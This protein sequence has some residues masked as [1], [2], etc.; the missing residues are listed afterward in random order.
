MARTPFPVASAYAP[1]PEALLFE[2][3]W[4]VCNQV[5]GIYQVLRS[6]VPTMV[7]RW[8]ERYWLVGPYE[9][10]QA[11]LEFEPEEPPS[12]DP[13][14]LEALAELHREGL[15]VHAGRWLVTGR[16]RVLLLEHAPRPEREDPERLRALHERMQR[17]F[18]VEPRPGD[19][20]LEGVLSFGEAVR[21]CLGTVARH[22]RAQRG[23]RVLA[24]FHEW[25]GG[26]ALPF[27]RQEA[28]REGLPLETVFTTHATSVGRYVASSHGDLYERLPS[29]D[30]DA[31]ATHFA[32]RTQHQ[33]ESL[34]ARECRV[35]TTVSP[36]T[37]E[38]CEALLGRRPDLVTPNGLGV[39]RY[40]VGHEFQ[41]LHGHYKEQI[42]HFTMGHFFG[43]Q[44]FDLERT[45]YFFTAGRY[46]PRN[47]GFDLCL[48]VMARLN[49]ELK[50]TD[51]GVT[52]VFFIVSARPVRSLDPAALHSRGV[53]DELRQVSRR[54]G[55]TVGER[56]F[57]RSA[58]GERVQLDELVDEYWRLR[59]LRVQHALRTDRLPGITTHLLEDA[60]QDPVLSQIRALGLRN[61]PDDPVKVVYHPEFISPTSPLWGMDYEQFVRGCHL[62][63]FPSSYEP[64]G[65]TPL[66]C[67]A[68]GVPAITSDLAGFGR[69]VAEVY[70]DHDDWGLVV[71]SRRGREFHDTAADLTRR[72]LRFCRLDRRARIALRNEVEQH[73]WAFDWSPLGG[74]YHEAHDLALAR[75]R[76]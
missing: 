22:V 9:A 56:L 70:P 36:L 31:Q 59:H 15:A 65:Y 23:R 11:E 8:G 74:A 57:R 3:S 27:L 66:E 50:E 43:S 6:K 41:T 25:L 68:M 14:L 20:L 62:G 35:F 30:A 49:A 17:E 2:V 44:A 33:I 29:L 21:R 69:F 18:G 10:H 60:G 26:A 16:P 5:G 55:D 13:Q 63:L 54:I 34:C 45:L 47:K 12:D 24:H 42:H 75:L 51:P 32:I 4:E 72:V 1:W 76:S 71:L 48:E 67:V 28:T 73:S 39:A 40:D 7:E 61:G 46:E 64:W 38:E 19:P 53:L 52:V 58:A 37:G